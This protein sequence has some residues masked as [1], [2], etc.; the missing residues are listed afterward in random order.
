MVNSKR[1]K[2]KQDAKRTPR[3]YMIITDY[4]NS[5]F[6]TD[7]GKFVIKKAEAISIL[8]LWRSEIIEGITHLFYKKK[9]AS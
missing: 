4:R 1:R 6:K 8:E 9:F 5:T 3:Y 2:K 7:H